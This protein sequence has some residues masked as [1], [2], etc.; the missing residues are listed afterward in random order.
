MSG[1]GGQPEERTPG[2]AADIKAV[3]YRPQFPS[4]RYEKTQLAHWFVQVG[5]GLVDFAVIGW[6][7]I[8]PTVAMSGHRRAEMTRYGLVVE[9]MIAVLV[10]V[11]EGRAGRT[12]GKALLGLR[13][14]DQTNGL[15]L[16]FWRALLRRVAHL[17]DGLSCYIGFLWPLWDAQ[18]QTFADKVT[19][20]VVVAR[21]HQ[22]Q[23]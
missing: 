6:P 7:V 23:A 4:N 2:Y 21:E 16:G 22:P 20:A 3:G 14:V 8:V 17:L 5:S 15:P 10:A 11:W 1:L 12:P 9:L 13:L 18:R 19:N